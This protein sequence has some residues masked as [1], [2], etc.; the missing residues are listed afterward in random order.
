MT[1]RRFRRNS[2]AWAATACALALGGGAAAQVELRGQQRPMDGDVTQV[3][4]KGVEVTATNPEGN[5]V[6]RLVGWDRIRKVNGAM[7]SDAGKFAELADGLWRA[8]ARLE[9]HDLRAA[10]LLFDSLYA[11]HAGLVGPGGAVL[12]EGVMRTR[13]LRGAT[14]TA[15]WP[16]LD[17]LQVRYASGKREM[18]SWVGGRIALPELLDPVRGLS[19]RLPPIFSQQVDAAGLRLLAEGGAS[20][21]WSR[22]DQADDAVREIASIYLAAASFENDPAK[23]I[24]L[25]SIKTTEDHVVMLA[26][27]VRAR[28]GTDQ[29]RKDARARLTRRV[30]TLGI[31]P[32]DLDG[33]SAG[34]VPSA[35]RYIESWCRVAI[36]RSLVREATPAE[37]R[38]GLIEMLHAPARFG[39]VTPELANLALL[40]AAAV[41]HGLGDEKAAAVLRDESRQ[42]FGPGVVDDW[43]I[44]D[45]PNGLGTPGPDTDDEGAG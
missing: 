36:G 18:D 41:L 20:S 39:D 5:K 16:W 45:E 32:D 8:R 10:E 13:L 28:I 2:N 14:A 6:I 27:I 42:R 23:A 1:R 34:N 17:W 19:P 21:T 33:E 35:G 26:D 44:K 43:R 40:D 4:A 9:R 38:Q 11:K 22:Y 30:A 3:D 37:V 7:A 12:A 29:E 15:I 24:T 31:S 25:P